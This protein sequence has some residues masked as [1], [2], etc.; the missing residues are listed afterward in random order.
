LAYPGALLA[1]LLALCGRWL[2]L[3]CLLLAPFAALAPVETYYIARYAHPSSAEILATVAAT[4]V[5]ETRE[6]FGSAFYLLAAFSLVGFALSLC[7]ALA[8]FHAGLRWRHRSRAWV[9]IIV[10][11]APWTVAIESILTTQGGISSRLASGFQVAWSLFDPGDSGYP[12]G[13]IHRVREFVGE[14]NSLRASEHALAN[15]RFHTHRAGTVRQRQIYVLVIGEASRRDHW[16]LFGYDRATNPELTKIANI[17]PISH[18]VASWS[19]SVMAIP[20]IITRKPPT[21][22]STIWN[23]ASILRGAQEA[24]FDTWWISNQMPMGKYDSPV[25]LYALEAAHTQFVNH[26][27]WTDVGGFDEALI[28]PLRDAA[29]ATNHDLFIVLHMLGSHEKYD[30]R[31]PSA[32]ERFTPTLSDTTSTVPELER[33]VNSYDNTI[34]YTDHVLAQIVGILHDSGAITA[35]WYESDHGENLPTSACSMRGHGYGTIHDL[36]IPALFW[37]SNAWATQFPDR[38][39]ALR[40]NANQGAMSANTFESL[41]DMAG[42]DFTGHDQSMCRFRAHW[43]FRPRMVNSYG[44]SDIDTS[45]LSKPCGMVLPHNS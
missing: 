3:P 29:H 19:A 7:A 16:Q 27:T 6:Y 28:E 32:F 26:A 39:S 22:A 11:A 37:Y 40:T 15:F 25:S 14:W 2:W 21:D 8:S 42:L 5:S 41:I 13:A 1:L 45:K 44:P 4:N 20:M 35:L 33:R 43:H 24:G 18:M 34:L 12:F 31:Y 30:L 36:Q 17:V 23:E 10:L 38:L 9:L